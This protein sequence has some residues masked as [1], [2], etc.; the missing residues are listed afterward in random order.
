[1]TRFLEFKLYGH[2][3]GNCKHSRKTVCTDS[4]VSWHGLCKNTLQA[5][6]KS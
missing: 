5:Y 1:M 2:G 6:I 4:D 3:H